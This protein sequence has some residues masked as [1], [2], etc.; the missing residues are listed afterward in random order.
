MAFFGCEDRFSAFVAG[1][2]SGKSFAGAVKGL[3]HAARRK[4][5]GVVTAPTYGM[6][7]DA[8]LRMYLDLAGDALVKLNRST[9]T[10]T[11]TNGSEL[12]FR[13]TDSPD[14]LRGP[15]ISWWHGDEAALYDRDV[16]PIMIGRLREGG[17]AGHA[18]VTTTPK[19]R[20][21]LYERQGEM[22]LFRAHT[23][24]NPYLD[25]GFV[26]SLAATY[27]GLFARQELDE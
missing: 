9:M 12:L 27:T 22:T 26:A 19:G 23:A 25:S 21:W 2:G 16:W 3:H 8:T 17:R 18:W 7:Q 15:S 6:L 11:L 5:L 20:N 1:I 14:R 4:C 24:D 13:S 10:A